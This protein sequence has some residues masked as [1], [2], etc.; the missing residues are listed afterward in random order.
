MYGDYSDPNQ[1]L[2]AFTSFKMKMN[3]IEI[4]KT[5]IQNTFD[6]KQSLI[7]AGVS[8]SDNI[9]DNSG[10]TFTGALKSQLLADFLAS[11]NGY[12]VP[13]LFAEMANYT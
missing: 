6:F 4:M 7:D 2:R 11:S 8:I 13:E 12:Y 1:H 10:D 5:A 3:Y 9:I